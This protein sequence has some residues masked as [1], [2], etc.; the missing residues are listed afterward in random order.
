MTQKTPRGVFSFPAKGRRAM[1]D[2]D[3]ARPSR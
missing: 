1:D 3:E 2:R